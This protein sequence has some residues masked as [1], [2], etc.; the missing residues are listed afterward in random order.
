ML[1]RFDYQEGER[2]PGALLFVTRYRYI[3]SA[4][5]MIHIHILHTARAKVNNE[6]YLCWKTKN[7]MFAIVDSRA[8][9]YL[10]VPMPKV[11][12]LIMI[13]GVN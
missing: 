13:L 6:R 11:R 5:F 2:R 4:W 10:E 7:C 1:D 9:F 8:E 12:R 3:T